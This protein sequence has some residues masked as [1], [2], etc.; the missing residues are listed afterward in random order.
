M[1]KGIMYMNRW[2]IFRKVEDEKNKVQRK[3]DHKRIYTKT[4]I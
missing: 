1:K 2:D 4:W 3:I